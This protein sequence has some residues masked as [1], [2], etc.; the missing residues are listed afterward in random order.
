MIR[1]QILFTTLAVVIS[2][3]LLLGCDNDPFSS[4]VEDPEDAGDIVDSTNNARLTI[5]NPVFDFGFT[6]QH[7]KVSHDFWLKSSGTDTVHILKIQPG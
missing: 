4:V 1:F 2:L 3:T 5:E 6:P 7:S